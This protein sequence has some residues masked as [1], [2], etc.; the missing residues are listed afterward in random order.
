MKKSTL[1]LIVVGIL[2]LLPAAGGADKASLVGIYSTESIKFESGTNK[3]ERTGA[4]LH[5]HGSS[6]IGM[7]DIG[8]KYWLGARKPLSW[9]DGTKEIDVKNVPTYWD[10]GAGVVY[11]APINLDMFLEIGLAFSTAYK[12]QQ[13]RP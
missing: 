11:Q 7:T 9:K 6:F 5:F 10:V 13:R 4:G 2:V 3:E 1:L 12:R 8:I